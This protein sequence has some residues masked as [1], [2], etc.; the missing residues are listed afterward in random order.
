MKK[1]K[2]ISL[3]LA[4]VLLLGFAS[5]TAEEPESQDSEEESASELESESESVSNNN[6]GGGSTGGGSTGD[7][8]TGGGSTNSK[9][10]IITVACIGDSITYGQ[11]LYDPKTQAY[12]AHMQNALGEGYKVLN[13]GKSGSTMCSTSAKIYQSKNWFKWSGYASTLE[14]EAK[15]VDV[16]FIMLGTNDGNGTEQ[17]LSKLFFENPANGENAAQKVDEFVTAFKADYK[18]NLEKF[19]NTLRT[20]NPDVV[21][22]L[23]SAPKAYDTK[24]ANCEKPLIDIVRPLQASLA[25]ELELELYDM[26]AFTANTVGQAGFYDRFHLGMDGSRKVGYELA[27]VLS[28]RYDTELSA[29]VAEDFSMADD[30]E[31]LA[32]G[33]VATVDKSGTISVG[34]NELKVTLGVDDDKKPIPV[35]ISADKGALILNNSTPKPAAYDFVFESLVPESKYRIEFEV[36]VTENLNTRGALFYV[37]GQRFATIKADKSIYDASETI[38]LG[39]KL[40]TDKFMK[41]TLDIDTENG[42]YVLYVDGVRIFAD[43]FVYRESLYFR[44]VQFFSDGEGGIVLNS[45]SIGSTE[46]TNWESYNP[47]DEGAGGGDTEELLSQSD[48]FNSLSS[49]FTLTDKDRETVSVGDNTMTVKLI[50]GATL[51]ADNGALALTKGTTEAWYNIMLD[52]KTVQG[53]YR[54]ELEVKASEDFS[55]RGCF[56]FIFGRQFAQFKADK[57]IINIKET[58]TDEEIVLGKLATD[59]FV[60]LTLDVDTANENYVLYI[61]GE[62]VLTESFVYK[63]S[64]YL[65]P[66]QFFG[67]GSG[68]IWLNSYSITQTE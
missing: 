48:D 55:A 49:S 45:F 42:K 53:K 3:L 28:E 61:D 66:M 11:G 4:G 56:F 38:D 27:R 35:T 65:R 34:N 52:K 20:A 44:P 40:A 46:N 31:N 6:S 39:V 5:C 23:M 67:G 26:Y 64:D 21:I 12:P 13:W 57:S 60:K 9:D 22:Y 18:A 2:W 43:S 41:L 25:E 47:N 24:N 29:Y 15:N 1:I 33:T 68:T 32:D 7:E 58:D 50:E 54:I 59:R 17:E 14:T 10:D 62:Q 19:V 37:F 51:S 63:E 16:A 36:K 8:S 30:F